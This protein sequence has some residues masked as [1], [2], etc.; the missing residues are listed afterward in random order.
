ML[1][2]RSK[3]PIEIWFGK[4]VG[5][6]PIFNTP[7]IEPQLLKETWAS[8]SWRRGRE[9]IDGNGAIISTTYAYFTIRYLSAPT[10]STANWIVCKGSDGIEQTFD[11]RDVQPD[12]QNRGYTVIEAVVRN[13][14][15]QA[16]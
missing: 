12:L 14:N 8:F 9:L 11:I 10:V 2:G 5:R 15:V 13:Q 6:D 4:E 1:P 16:E 3:V 7:V